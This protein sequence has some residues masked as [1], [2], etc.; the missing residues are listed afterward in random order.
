[1]TPTCLRLTSGLL[2]A[3]LVLGLV[4]CSDDDGDEPTADT[5]AETT[6]AAAETTVPAVQPGPDAGPPFTV[7]LSGAG[8]V[9]GPGAEGASG[10]LAVT[11]DPTGEI[12]VN[13]EVTGLGPITGGIVGSGG[14]SEETTEADVQIDLGITTAGGDTQ[15]V[16]VCTPADA[17]QVADLTGELEEDPGDYF[18]S[19]RTADLPDGAVRGQLAAA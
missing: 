7:T 1:M 14:D 17:E 6:D 3:G 15:T 13:G 5:S 12:C 18:V 8:E 10:T 19:L 2:A 16:S 9:P 11:F 4:A